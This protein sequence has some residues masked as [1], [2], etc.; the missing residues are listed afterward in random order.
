MIGAEGGPLADLQNQATRAD[1]ATL[2]DEI[3]PGR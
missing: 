2:V 1:I 3:P